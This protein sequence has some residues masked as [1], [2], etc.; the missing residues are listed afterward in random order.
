MVELDATGS[1]W[2]SGRGSSKKTKPNNLKCDTWV[3]FCNNKIEKNIRSFRYV[4]RSGS[5]T[6]NKLMGDWESEHCTRLRSQDCLHGSPSF[7][8][9]EEIASIAKVL[10]EWQQI[11]R[12]K[13]QSSEGHHNLFSVWEGRETH[14]AF[15]SHERIPVVFLSRIPMVWIPQPLLER[16]LKI[17]GWI[18]LTILLR[19]ATCFA[20]LHSF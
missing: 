8:I 7:S 4:F 18:R 14:K 16:S 3:R 20:L 19:H 2:V 9:S 1:V 15:S 11:R 5:K 13:N 10:L 17:Y 6:R 12:S